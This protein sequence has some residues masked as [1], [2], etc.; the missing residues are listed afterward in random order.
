MRSQIVRPGPG[1]DPDVMGEAEDAKVPPKL[2]SE[3][4]VMGL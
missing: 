2:A 3:A 4:D 1:V